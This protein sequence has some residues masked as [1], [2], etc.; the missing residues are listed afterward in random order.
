MGYWSLNCLSDI[1]IEETLWYLDGVL[2]T[3]TS[4]G[5]KRVESIGQQ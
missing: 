4:N 1:S 5:M 3:K 2:K